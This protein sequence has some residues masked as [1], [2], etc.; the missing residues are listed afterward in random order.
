[1]IDLQKTFSSCMHRENAS[2]VSCVA[3]CGFIS[4][5]SLRVRQTAGNLHLSKPKL[6]YLGNQNSL[7]VSFACHKEDDNFLQKHGSEIMQ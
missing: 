1:M 6:L 3:Q 4:S 7:N 5:M 2:D